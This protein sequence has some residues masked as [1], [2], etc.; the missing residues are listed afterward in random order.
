MPRADDPRPARTRAAIATAVES[1]SL[2]GAEVTV[3]AL[4]DAAGISRSTFYAQYRDLDALAVAILS[5]AFAAIEAED[6]EMRQSDR[7]RSAAA[8]ATRRLVTEFSRRRALYAGVLGSRAS[9]TAMRAVQSAFAEQALGTIRLLAPAHIDHRM[10]ADHL[11]GGTLAVIAAWLL[12]DDPP[13]P[14]YLQQQLL[15]LLPAWLIADDSPD[16]RNPS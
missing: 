7:A 6:L 11:A 1:L 15:A 8:V 9:A 5:E 2:R 13:D 12:A 10:A 16:E 3:P 4:A 14:E